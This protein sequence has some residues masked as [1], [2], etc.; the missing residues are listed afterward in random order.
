MKEKTT[1]GATLI[2][3]NSQRF[4]V[5]NITCINGKAPDALSSLPNPHRVFI[6]GSGGNLNDILTVCQAKLLEGGKIVMAFAT[7]EHGYQA[8]NWFQHNFWNY[9]LLQLHISRSAPIN[10]LTRMT[11][12][13][14]VTIITASAKKKTPAVIQ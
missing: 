11:P 13:N 10:H 2:T 5:S 6:G 14:P 3:Q 7:I 9:R 4:K 1:M 8:I 12:L